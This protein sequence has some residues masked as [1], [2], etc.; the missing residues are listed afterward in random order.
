MPQIFPLNWFVISL[1]LLIT[2]MIIMIM[3]YFMMKHI[4]NMNMYSSKT[5]KKTILFKW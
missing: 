4:K 3:T 2:I 5:M 1:L